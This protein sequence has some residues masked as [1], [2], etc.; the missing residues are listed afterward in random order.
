M[1]EDG[2]FSITRD[3]YARAHR[4]AAPLYGFRY[5]GYWKDLGSAASIEAAGDDLRSGRFAA[6]YL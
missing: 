4:E 5:D 3:T 2:V 6:S 1:P